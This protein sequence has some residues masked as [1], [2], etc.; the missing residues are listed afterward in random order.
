[1]ERGLPGFKKFVKF[2]QSRN[3]KTLQIKS[4]ILENTGHS[5]NKAEGYARGLHYVFERPSLK[6]GNKALTKYSGTYKT[7]KGNTVKIGKENAR[8]VASFDNANKDTLYAASDTDF[9]AKSELLNISFKTD[10]RKVTGFE[11][12]RYGGVEIVNKVQ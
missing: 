9:N 10:N 7:A 11:L 12:K 1:M 6:L 8:L 4:R 2:L 3:Y 5:G